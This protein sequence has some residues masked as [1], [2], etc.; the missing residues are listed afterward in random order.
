MATRALT[1]GAASRSFSAESAEHAETTVLAR[2]TARRGRSH[3]S[4][5]PYLPGLD[6]LR[7]IAVVAVM[8]YHA[9]SEWLPGGFLGVE[10]FFVISGYLITLLLI[11]EHEK[12]G[13]IRLGQFW[14]RRARRLLPALFLMLLL[15][16]TY[17]AIFR[18]DALGQLRGDV[19]AGIGYVSNWYQVVVGAGYTAAGDFAPLRHLWSLAVEEQ[20]YLVWPL[21]MILLLRRGSRRIAEYAKWLV[22]VSVLITVGMALAYHRGTIG[23]CDVTPGAY[24]VVGERCISK[25]DAL[26]LATIT[27]APSLLLGAAFA[28]VWRPMAIMRSPLRTKGHLLDVVAVAGL[29]GLLAMFWWVHFTTPDGAAPFIFRGG[30]LL[31]S[32]A[33]IAIIAAVTHRRSL[34]GPVLGNPLFL[35]VG[36][37]SYGLYLY[38]WPIYQ[39]IRE[40]AGNPLT[41]GEF[42][43]AMA[44]TLV[45]T[46]L[47]YRYVE[48][49][50]RRRVVGD[51]LRGLRTARDPVPRQ[52]VFGTAA[53]AVVVAMF[54]GYSMFTAPLKQNEIAVS[55][56]E[57]DDATTDLE[58]LIGTTS[59]GTTDGATSTGTTTPAP[60]PTTG[61]P[62]TDPATGATVPVTAPVT[63]APTTTLPPT[64]TTSLPTEPIPLL[65][66]GDSVMLGA[67]PVLQEGGMTVSAEVSRQMKDMIPVMQEMQTRGL[68]GMAVVVHLGTNG[69]FSDET[70]SEF[71]ATLSGVPNVLLLTARANRGWIA[72][73]NA[74]LRALDHEG[75]NIILVDWETLS[76]ECPGDCYY[77]DGI[78]LKEAGQQYYARQI[79]DVLGI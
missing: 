21:V 73:N 25:A 79:F 15:L 1:R 33:T 48:M 19:L 62:V 56:A 2:T 20:F 47:S 41:V 65:A 72:E 57:A 69:P 9:S 16:V 66:I 43:G 76:N 49:P 67:A 10:V 74:K 52:L 24:W 53:I 64:T 17:T 13:R 30:L 78:H 59:D 28:M 71:M 32:L 50:I 39:I 23:E 6:G 40:V 27:R 45:I 54:G 22:L 8:V 36:T 5:M 42:V 68:F 44:I 4:K 12:T 31:V 77:A 11:G 58:A 18:S 63:E 51:W 55:L 60:A 14:L 75:D 3:I 26:Y 35:W 46:E 38:H 34:A 7:A 29:L 70:L 37:R 61:A